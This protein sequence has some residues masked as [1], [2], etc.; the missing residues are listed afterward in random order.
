MFVLTVCIAFV[1]SG[2]H[3]IITLQSLIV[4]QTIT[5]LIHLVCVLLECFGV[6]LL[7]V[8]VLL[9]IVLL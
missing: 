5:K 7:Q 9:Q 4:E 1:Y 6:V 2:P 8:G 3:S